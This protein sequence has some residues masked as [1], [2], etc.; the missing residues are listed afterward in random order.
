MKCPGW[1]CGPQVPGE[2]SNPDHGTDA[3][4]RAAVSVFGCDS[5]QQSTAID[6]LRKQLCNGNDQQLAAERQFGCPV[7]VGK[8]AEVADAL[9]AGRQRVHEEAPNELIVVH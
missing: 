3:A 8:K 6:R 9:K 5:L 1:H 4:T 7:T 2:C